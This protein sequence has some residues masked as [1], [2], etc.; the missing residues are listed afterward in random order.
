MKEFIA[1]ILQFSNLNPQ[2]ID[3]ISQR[4]ELS[5][6]AKDQYFAEAGKEF[7]KVGFILEGVFRAL[8]YNNS[9]DE[10]TNYFFEEQHLLWNWT[11]LNEAI[12]PTQY[13]QAATPVKL[14]VFPKKEWK[15]IDDTVIDWDKIILKIISKN[16]S[17]KLA[18]RS[19]LVSKSADVKY[20]EF[21]E[22]YPTLVNRIPLS[23]VASYLGITPSSLSRIRKRIC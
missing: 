22:N 14:I 9:G 11:E 7:K 5:E 17:E 2:Q 12:I 13:L 15:E 6:I 4:G 16:H 18:R 1:Y 3:F 19:S 10:I 23:Y 21:L 8:Y 20:R